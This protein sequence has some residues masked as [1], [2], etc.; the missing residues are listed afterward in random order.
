M[1]AR[2][3]DWHFVD[4]LI[5]LA[6]VAIGVVEDRAQ[7]PFLLVHIPLGPSIA[8]NEFRPALFADHADFWFFPLSHHSRMMTDIAREGRVGGQ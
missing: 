6:F 5:A 8:S 7:H 3:S 1:L 2:L 4:M